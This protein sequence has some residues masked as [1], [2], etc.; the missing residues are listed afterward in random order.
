[1]YALKY[2]IETLLNVMEEFPDIKENLVEIAQERE[3]FRL[4]KQKKKDLHHDEQN[5]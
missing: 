5:R 1:V 4:L 3:K 2:D